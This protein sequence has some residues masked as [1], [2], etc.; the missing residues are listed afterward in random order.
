MTVVGA[1]RRL[2]SVWQVNFV[3]SLAN[4]SIEPVGVVEVPNCHEVASSN[5][6]RSFDDEQNSLL[7]PRALRFMGFRS[8][9]DRFS[10]DEAWRQFHHGL[11]AYKSHRV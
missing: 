4:S 5:S 11:C 7:M 6:Q 10:C 9:S 2:F 1:L 3:I 8:D